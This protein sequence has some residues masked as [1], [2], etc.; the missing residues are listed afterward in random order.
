MTPTVPE[1]PITGGPDPR[2]LPPDQRAVRHV[3]S[4]LQWRFSQNPA[5]G[6]RWDPSC[7]A[8]EGQKGSEIVL[9]SE[10][11][12]DPNGGLGARPAVTIDAGGMPFAGGGI[13]DKA[14]VDL[15]TGATVRMDFIP[16]QLRINVLSSVRLEARTLAWWITEQIWAFRDIIVKLEPCLLSLGQRPMISPPLPPGSLLSGT[17]SEQWVLVVAQ[18]PMVLQHSLTTLPLNKRILRELRVPIDLPQPTTP[19]AQSEGS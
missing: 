5:G 11:P 13:G 7:L 4:F 16:T 12:L 9:T 2:V 15:D 14:F 3:L 10:V 17:P 8:A 6:Y 18:F 1:N 19:K